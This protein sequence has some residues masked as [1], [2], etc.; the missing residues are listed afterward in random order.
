MN[1]HESKLKIMIDCEK[2]NLLLIDKATQG[3]QKK[4]GYIL[5]CMAIVFSFAMSKDSNIMGS[6]YML[7]V[8]VCSLFFSAFFVFIMVL[9][10]KDWCAYPDSE[11]YKDR[12]N[13]LTE[14]AFMSEILATL[15]FSIHK[16]IKTLKQRYIYFDLGL[17]YL[18]LS[19]FLIC[20]SHYIKVF[21]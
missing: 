20:L 11:K 2:A 1:N 3:L 6:F 7:N 8:F 12:Y 18:G 10:G 21:L 17:I 9:R 14:Y 16:N 19:I 15:K 5:L 13:E 4:T